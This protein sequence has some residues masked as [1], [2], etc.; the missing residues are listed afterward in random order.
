MYTVI[1]AGN[2]SEAMA[3][4]SSQGMSN[5]TTRPVSRADSL[6]GLVISKVVELPSY[7]RRPDRFAIEAVLRTAGRRGSFERAL[8]EG[9]VRPERTPEGEIPG[10][11]TLPDPAVIEELSHIADTQDPGGIADDEVAEEREKERPK[12]KPRSKPKPVE[13]QKR[14]YTDPAGPV[15]AA[16]FWKGVE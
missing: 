12:T 9:W 6:R 7:A 4:A 16:S 2:Y 3:Y 5:R 15:D 8:V 14:P 1:L 13:D 10:Q 11:L